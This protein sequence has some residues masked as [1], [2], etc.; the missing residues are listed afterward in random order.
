M[1]NDPRAD[2]G[3]LLLERLQRAILHWPGRRQRVDEVGEVA[4][5]KSDTRARGG[6]NLKVARPRLRTY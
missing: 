4:S 3:Q 6:N 2:I 5:V 1:S